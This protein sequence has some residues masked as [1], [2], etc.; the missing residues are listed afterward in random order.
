MQTKTIYRAASLVI[1]IGILGA[2][3]E[4]WG[5][6]AAEATPATAP[7]NK[8]DEQ[9]VTKV[10]PVADLV[11]SPP[12]YPFEGVDLGMLGI[13]KKSQPIPSGGGFGGG[14]FGGGGFG[15]S[16]LGGGGFAV[17][18]EGQ[19]SGKQ[20]RAAA[21]AG[22]GMGGGMP[23][24]RSLPPLSGTPSIDGLI[25][26]IQSVIHPETWS[27]RGGQGMI[28]QFG[29]R[30]IVT[31]TQEV[32]NA[33][34]DLLNALRNTQGGAQSTVTIRAW[35]LRLDNAQYQKLTSGMPPASPPAVDRKQFDQ[36]A[37]EKGVDSG[38]VTCFDGQTVHIISGRFRSAITSVIP[39]VGQVEPPSDS[40]HD[41]T[42]LAR[43]DSREIDRGAGTVFCAQ[44]DPKPSAGLDGII[45]AAADETQTLPGGR[46]IPADGV[47]GYQP[48]TTIQ[49]AGAMLEVTPTRLPERRAIILDLRSVMNRW[50]AQPE[51]PIEFRNSMP[52]DRTNVVSQQLSTTVKVPVRTPVLVGGLSLQPGAAND[53]DSKSQLYLVIEAF[54][55][56]K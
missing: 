5:Q 34:R 24:A 32:H 36:L 11:F 49:H 47:V 2:A 3:H 25:D 12:N 55:E 10:Y 38:Q 45:L 31:Q 54:D 18:P 20:S 21:G 43:I 6:T 17:P 40:S 46:T 50:D 8:P 35:W 39:V 23:E 26:V 29:G 44:S 33:I 30:L 28:E 4:A 42:A 14:G 27:A 22:G 53:A 19:P 16:G 9:L 52:L 51:K 37:S 1:A 7:Q 13:T 48:Q 56:S 15:G 41:Q